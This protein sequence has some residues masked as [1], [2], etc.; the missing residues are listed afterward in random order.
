M[1]KGDVMQQMFFFLSIWFLL[2]LGLI[3]FEGP[4]LS[5][6]VALHRLI[7]GNLRFINDQSQCP[8]RDTERRAELSTKQH[9]FAVIIA[10]SD[11]RVSPDIIFDQGVGDLFVVR[12]AG[13]VV[14]SLELNSIDYAIRILNAS[15]IVVV[16]HENCGAVDAVLQGK[17]Q[18]FPAIAKLIEPAVQASK[19][20]PGNA[21]D[22][23]IK[24]NVHKMVYQL[25]NFG[26]FK[27][28]IQS[29]ELE[30]LGAY[31]HLESGKVEFFKD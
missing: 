18:D 7:D 11:S 2:P 17:A 19:N 15:L 25:K 29:N 20:Q 23:A 30:V 9:P 3:G 31:Y 1:E 27:T 16:G 5:P 22:N 13:N 21:L 8:D 24:T 6:Q 26:P 12:V 14:G 28:S 10:C 4:K